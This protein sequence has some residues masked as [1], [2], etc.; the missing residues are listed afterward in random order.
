MGKEMKHLQY[1]GFIVDDLNIYRSTKSKKPQGR[2]TPWG[3]NVFYGFQ[4][5]T[6]KG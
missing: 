2:P 1:D 6:K 5:E 4:K 3:K